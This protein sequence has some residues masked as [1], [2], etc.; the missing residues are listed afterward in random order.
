MVALWLAKEAAEDAVNVTTVDPAATLTVAGTERAVE[1]ELRV[2]VSPALATASAMV[3]LVDALA[4]IDVGLQ[5]TDETVSTGTMGVTV[6]PTPVTGITSPVGVAPT[7]PD[8]LTATGTVAEPRPT[9]TVATAPSGMA[10]AFMPNAIHAY[11]PLTA[12]HVMDL[13]AATTAGLALTS[14]VLVL[15]EG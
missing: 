10:F 3:Q 15:A 4:P 14:N 6:P 8:R 7:P 1:L 5:T 11:P 9:E 12:L 2:T 13:P